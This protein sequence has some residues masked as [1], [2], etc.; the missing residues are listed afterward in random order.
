ML[1]VDGTDANESEIS[2]TWAEYLSDEGKVS[3]RG[4]TSSDYVNV[5]VVGEGYES[6]V[7]PCTV[8][9]GSFSGT[10]AI[11]P[12][13]QGTYQIMFKTPEFSATRS[14]QVSSSEPLT[15]GSVQYDPIDSKISFEGTSTSDY[16]NVMVVGEGYES[17]VKPC[18]VTNGSF[19]GMFA[20]EPLAPGSYHL[21]V[22]SFEADRT[23]KF[24]VTNAS[25]IIRSVTFDPSNARITIMGSNYSD[26]I[27]GLTLVA[28]GGQTYEMKLW[29]NE[30]HSFV[31]YAYVGRLIVNGEYSLRALPSGADI[32]TYTYTEQTNENEIDLN[33]SILCDNG[34]TL[35]R[36]TGS[37]NQYS[38]PSSVVRV[39]EGAFDNCTIGTFVLDR[40]VNWELKIQD[41]M[42]YP[43][44]NVNLGRVMI[45]EGVTSIPDYLFAKSN[46]TDVELPSSVKS[47]GKKSF[48]DCDNITS[49]VVRDNSCLTLLGEYSFSYDAGLTTVSFGSSADGYQCEF[50]MGAFLYS[51]NLRTVTINPEFNLKTIGSLCFTKELKKG[52]GAETLYAIN[53][54][55]SNG[56]VI[57]KEVEEIGF[58]AFSTMSEN[59]NIV[60]NISP[61]TEPLIGTYTYHGEGY[62]TYGG[63]R[64]LIGESLSISF[65]SESQITSIGISAFGGYADVKTIDLSNCQ[66]LKVIQRIAFGACLNE[67]V[68]YLP[69]NIEEMY[70]AFD[71]S[72][73]RVEGLLPDSLRICDNALSDLSGALSVSNNSSLVYWSDNKVGAITEL[74]LTGADGLEHVDTGCSKVSLPAG[75]FEGNI[76]VGKLKDDVGPTVTDS[77]VTI[78]A[79][80]TFLNWNM[81]TKEL[82]CIEG[83][84]Y[85]ND[86]GSAIYFEKQDVCKLLQI[87]QNDDFVLKDGIQVR[88]GIV[89]QSIVDLT[90]GTGVQ[91][92]NN[93]LSSCD[94]LQ[95][96]NIS[97]AIDIAMLEN[98]L[99]GLTSH[100]IIIVSDQTSDSDVLKLSVYGQVYYC[101]TVD[102]KKVNVPATLSSNVL[103]YTI[104]GNHTLHVDS[105]LENVVVSSSGVRTSFDNDAIVL[106]GI[107]SDCFIWLIEYEE[108]SQKNPITLDANGGS[109]G[110][111]DRIEIL[112]KT[113]DTL[114]QILDIP[115]RN[116][117]DFVGWSLEPNGVKLSEDHI[118]SE[119]DKLYALWSSRGPR[120]VIDSSAALIFS[121]GVQVDSLTLSAGSTLVL[122]AQPKS[123]Y[124]LFDWS[125]NGTIIGSA[126]QELRYENIMNDST[127]SV[128]FRYYS[129]SSGLNTI[130]NRGLPTMSETEDLVKV[131]ELGGRLSATSAI[132]EGHASVPLVVDDRIYF[133]A[134]PRL[135]AAESDT[136]YIIANVASA[137]AEDYYHQLG[138]GAGIIIDYKTGKAYDLDL[139][140]LF[141]LPRT[142]YGVEYYNGMFYT[143]GRDVYAFSATD[144]DPTSTSEEKQMTFIGHIDNV[145]STYGFSRSAFVDHYMY[146]IVVDGKE[147]GIAAMDLDTGVVQVKYLE[148]IRSMF[149]DDGWISYNEG[150]LYLPG[151]T[152][153][154]FGAIATDGYDALAFVEVNGLN[155]GNENYY[156]F[157]GEDYWTSE[158]I[159]YDGKAYIYAGGKLYRFDITDGKIDCNTVSYVDGL[160]IGHGGMVMET[161]Y[162]K[163]G[164]E[165]LY[166]YI[167]PYTS[168]TSGL[169]VVEDRGGTMT[170]R[171]V[172]GLPQDYNSQAVRADID[173]RM[174]WYNDSGHIY[175][176]TTPEKNV[177]YFFIED[178][179]HAQWY[180]AHGRNAAEALKSLGGDIISL[181]DYKRVISVFGKAVD[182]PTIKV[183]QQNKP[184]EVASNLMSY[185]WVKLNDLY[186]RSYDT[187][188]YYRIIASG[189]GTNSFSYIDDYG[190]VSAYTFQN[191]IGDGRKVLGKMLVPGND[192][193]KIMFF[194]GDTELTDLAMIY[195]KSAGA[196]WD[197]PSMIRDGT[198]VVWTTS[199]GDAVTSLAQ[200]TAGKTDVILYGTWPVSA[201]D[202]SRDVTVTAEGNVRTVT[203][204]LS[205][206]EGTLYLKSVISNGNGFSEETYELKQSDNWTKTMT[207]SE[208]TEGMLLYLV[209]S[210]EQ[211]FADNIGCTLLT[212]GAGL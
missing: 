10:F 145:Y 99:N 69:P 49:V 70:E 130:S 181:D 81:L 110:S 54:N 2:I 62:I 96:L 182:K 139:R 154:L 66:K 59:R 170:C 34:S 80:T 60:S 192:C 113:G 203:V 135:Y 92:D 107:Q 162:D 94:S 191:N 158:T 115:T 100:P 166:F 206:Q 19:S 121:N 44:Q 57:P 171:L 39:M 144:D 51:S 18:T 15:L 103:H 152:A 109:F 157:S 4:T 58:L 188:H 151:Y 83:N 28:P 138:Y 61:N 189:N 174:I 114:S 67:G 196:S 26:D 108:L 13:P 169:T 179:E 127:V 89:G 143:S 176:Y 53:F 153:G 165:V 122:T 194:D 186:D 36:F 25:L 46:I 71:H 101:L 17:Q 104:D 84:A 82:I 37:V 187:C 7:K 204:T 173:G 102:S 155:F 125:V 180:E 8:T 147:R 12:L 164:E 5:M 35:V 212:A 136:G 105:V 184:T 75:V 52:S 126:S 65:E 88:E 202:L 134:G 22:K 11:G 120:V 45:K 41:G 32:D 117:N 160:V 20:I 27:T 119:G 30:D 86:D 183:L 149:L 73:G 148:S 31:S 129:S 116:L 85:F 156:R 211:S 87:K 146:R 6:Q 72:T 50:G 47:V 9:N 1:I 123:G 190:T 208:G 42:T 77:T 68:L 159:F 133:R 131:T 132:W 48:Y 29:T 64:S 178:G 74:I 172:Y 207:V 14:M 140:P 97:G 185:S 161:S 128:T 111:E 201:T 112:I 163:M 124:E 198:D 150:Y 91:L 195:S 200:A 142:V 98:A 209:R 63:T 43:F 205:E 16:V 3:F 33:G 90:L 38:L 55:S 79:T 199:S 168:F 24:E 56:I 106:D 21:V 193:A 23:C 175:N 93:S 177:Y 141:T 78:K 95:T 118:L 167:I 137:E 40:D 210:P 76:D 197:L